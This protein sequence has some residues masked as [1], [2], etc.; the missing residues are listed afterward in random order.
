MTGPSCSRRDDA[1]AWVLGALPEDDARL[2]ARHLETC[3]A[4][5]LEVDDLRAVVDVLPLAAPQHVPPPE[6]R[7]RIMRVVDAEAELLRAAGPEA[8]LPPQPQRGSRRGPLAWLGGLG[9][10]LAAGMACALIAVGVVV[11]IVASGSGGG[12]VRE[13]R[14]AAPPG[15]RAA[16]HVDGDRGE[17]HLS[18]MPPP[19]AGRVYQVWIV[20]GNGGPTPTHT[21]FTVA[22]DGHAKVAIDEPLDEARQVMVSDEPDG[23]SAS[24]T[25]KV[26]VDA[27]LT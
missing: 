21:L 19:P 23:G 1:G 7:D 15:A 24:P 26:V 8:D 9:P 20:R 18:K 3:A 5:R 4:C 10:A 2:Y 27:R 6:L 12:G 22:R 11:G 16:L 25:G 14:A 17:L 13:F